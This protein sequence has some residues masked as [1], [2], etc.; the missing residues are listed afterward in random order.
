MWLKICPHCHYDMA[1]Y[2]LPKIFKWTNSECFLS[3]NFILLH[4]TSITSEW[5][6]SFWM[7]PNYSERNRCNILSESRTQPNYQVSTSEGRVSV[8]F[9][10]MVFCHAATTGIEK[11]VP[12]KDEIM[13]CLLTL[14]H[15]SGKTRV[16]QLLIHFETGKFSMI[17]ITVL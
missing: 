11:I 10:A 7:V 4:W 8:I 15:I 13:F 17:S 14:N 6:W 3:S 9:M 2:L 16:L 1:S 12:I 5:V